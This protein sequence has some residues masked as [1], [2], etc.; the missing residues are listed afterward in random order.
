MLR[1][2][3][4]FEGVQLLRDGQPCDVDKISSGRH[5]KAVDDWDRHECGSRGLKG[6][7]FAS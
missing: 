1:Y 3:I 6:P 2:E 5:D 4:D 7:H